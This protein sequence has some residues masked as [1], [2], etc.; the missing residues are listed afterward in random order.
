MNR[1]MTNALSVT[2]SERPAPTT[3]ATWDALARSVPGG[4]VSQLSSWADVRRGANFEP[5]YLLVYR[6]DQIVGGALI[7]KRKLPVIG[8]LCYVPYGPLISPDADRAAVVAV[9]ATA[10]R[11]FARRKLMLLFVQPPLDAHDLSFELQRHG[12]RPSQAGIAP[13]ASLRLDLANDEDALRAGLAKRLQTWT[14]RW[15]ARGV[16]VR[17]GTQD[18]IPLF[19]RLH[20]ATAQHQGFPPFSLDYLHTLY[21]LL[22]ATGSAELFIAEINGRPVA[23][24]LY[25]ACGGVLKLRLVGMSRDDEA[26]KL[27]V[28]AAVEWEA[29]R[30]AKA[31]GYRWFDFGGIREAA[32]S[33]LQEDGPGSPALT[34]PE[35]FKAKFGGTPFRY[36]T[37]VEIMAPSIVRLTYDLSRRWPV[38]R[39]LIDQTVRMLRTSRG[40]GALGNADQVK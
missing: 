5:L 27:S 18:D 15:P 20:A 2:L 39:R 25:T 26:A 13:N 14:R 29:I 8:A 16:H 7:L 30:W 24:R 11:Q 21:G 1:L 38:T 12:F 34:S 6:E 17:R 3:L 28:A 4:D 40:L 37:P 32:I 22:S 9:L 31:K 10:L 36:P 35:A 33:A 23:A 19:T